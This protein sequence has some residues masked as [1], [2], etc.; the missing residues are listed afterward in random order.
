MMDIAKGSQG[1][2]L[3]FKIANNLKRVKFNDTLDELVTTS[4]KQYSMNIRTFL[5]GIILISREFHPIL[6]NITSNLT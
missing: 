2:T 4:I 5:H 3:Q 1:Q 6:L